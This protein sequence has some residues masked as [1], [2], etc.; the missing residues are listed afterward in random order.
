[1]KKIINLI[2]IVVLLGGMF[3]CNKTTLDPTLS[4]NKDINTSI[5]TVEDLQALLNGAYDRMVYYTYYGRDYI[6]FGEVRSDNCF[7]NGNSGRF[8]TA[9]AMQMLPTDAYPTDTWTQMYRV[10]SNANIIIGVDPAKITGDQ[11]EIKNIIGQAYAIRA[12]VHFDLL[13]LYGEEHVTGGND[14]GIP[15]VMKYGA[16][17]DQKPARNTV[18]EV[19]TDINA[20]LASALNMMS[21]SLNDP[22]KEFISTYA[23]YAL[24]S[25]VDLY[26]GDWAAC[27]TAA[28]TVMNS[29]AYVIA[30]PANYAATFSSKGASNVIFELAERSNDNQ[31]INGLSYMYRGNSYGDVQALDTLYGIFDANDVRRAAD[32]LAFVDGKLRNIGKYPTNSNFDYD[33]PLIRYEEVVLNYA[34]AM[35]RLNG[36]NDTDALNALNSITAKRLANAYTAP[37]TEADI[38]QERRRELCFEGFRF[39]DLARTGQGIPLVSIHQSMGTVNYGDFN[40]AFPIPQSEINANP[41]ITQNKGY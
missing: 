33:I 28:Q 41:N 20:D 15:Y 14:V 30:D 34:E 18:A 19:K 7:S 22:S 3:S 4:Q 25:R 35:F 23:V 12:L 36:G 40:Y 32:M 21:T 17:A 11:A 39:D 8:I 26:F 9:A 6:I 29:G 13:K 38:L 10:I 27:A 16:D 2:L 5:N 37:I 1:M 24:Q 31:N